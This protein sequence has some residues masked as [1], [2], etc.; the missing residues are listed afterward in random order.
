M[1]LAALLPLGF[2]PLAA[3]PSL[4]AMLVLCVV[5]GLAI[6]PLLAVANQLVGDVA[7]AGALTEAYTWPITA[8]VVGVALGNARGRR[9][10]RG[11]RLAR[12]RSSRRRPAPAPGRS[13]PSPAARRS[14]RRATPAAA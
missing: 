13:S 12:R 10:G 7:P 14:C 2:L 6:A 4:A 11:G 1:R 9:P 5:A 8:L 3:A